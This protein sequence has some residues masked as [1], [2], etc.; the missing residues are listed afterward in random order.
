MYP[1][2]FVALSFILQDPLLLVFRSHSL[3]QITELLFSS[4]IVD[5]IVVFCCV[6][7]MLL[8]DIY[9]SKNSNLFVHSLDILSTRAVFNVHSGS[10]RLA[11]RTYFRSLSHQ[12]N[13]W[14]VIYLR[15]Y[16]LV[17][18]LYCAAQCICSERQTRW[19][20]V[21]YVVEMC[22]EWSVL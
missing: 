11:V 8:F 18:T 3:A 9:F 6:I 5:I 7:S 1:L 22:N 20:Q 12:H 14:I 13:G 19:F 4:L 17:F 2:P 10:H 21:C 15:I 16:C